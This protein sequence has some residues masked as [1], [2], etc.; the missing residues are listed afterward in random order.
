MYVM[1]SAG[2]PGA[3]G[4]E[5]LAALRQDIE[6]RVLLQSSAA[7]LPLAPGYSTLSAGESFKDS[8]HCASAR[9][10]LGLT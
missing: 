8:I 4:D 3:T 1:A 6:A 9:A 10:S 2:L 5:E 7:L